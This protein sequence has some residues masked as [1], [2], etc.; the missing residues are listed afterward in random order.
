MQIFSCHRTVSQASEL[1]LKVGIEG[2][3][4][5][6]SLGA[7]RRQAVLAHAALHDS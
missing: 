2:T 7:V 1:F 4:Y 6:P 5:L 3:G